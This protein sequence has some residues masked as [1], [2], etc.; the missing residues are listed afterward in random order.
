MEVLARLAG[1]RTAWQIKGRKGQRDGRGYGDV[2]S[3]QPHPL[4]MPRR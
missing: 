4:Q 2:K 1:E 3:T